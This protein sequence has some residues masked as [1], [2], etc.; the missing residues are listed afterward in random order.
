MNKKIENHLPAALAVKEINRRG[1]KEQKPS[2]CGLGGKNN[3]AK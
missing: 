1:H 2:L 3:N